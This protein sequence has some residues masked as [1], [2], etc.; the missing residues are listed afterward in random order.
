MAAEDDDSDDKTE[1]PSQRR[2]DEARERG[3]V[4]LSRD[5]A[6]AVMLAMATGLTMLAVP[7]LGVQALG[8]LRWFLQHGDAPSAGLDELR[9]HLIHLVIGLAL[10]IAVPSLGFVLAAIAS[11]V[12]QQGLFFSAEQ[13]VPKAERISPLAGFAK[14]FSVQ[15]LLEFLKSA[16]KLASVGVVA[17]LQLKDQL[18]L[19][20]DLPLREPAEIARQLAYLLGHL[21]L[22][23]AITM[24]CFALIDLVHQRF[25][26]RRKMR[27]SRQDLKEEMKQS[28][29]DP[30]IKQRLRS[31]RMAK[32]RKRMMA[33]V[34]SATVVIT[35]PTHYAVALR[36]EKDQDAAPVVVAKGV[37]HLAATIR[38]TA[39]KHGVPI[40]ENPPL[41]RALHAMAEIG[42]PI[43]T[44][45]Y[46]AVAEVI[47]MV[48]RLRRQRGPG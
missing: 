14:L 9:S 12:G 29:G 22:V 37:D 30:A 45:H 46:R 43:P 8:T 16:A 31:I 39:T 17:W 23:C 2:L 32:A 38:E 27:M 5:V 42:R 40:I 36:Y 1:E 7:A 11:T 13:L 47:I 10:V 3:Q 34:P 41:A 6:H 44:E 35:N 15:S 33:D 25:A 24:G 48:M 20:V 4:P 28:D 21:L 26:F 18:V 19:A